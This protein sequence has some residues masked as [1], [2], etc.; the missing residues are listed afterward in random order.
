M[1][2]LSL[3]ALGLIFS[4]SV[5]SQVEQKEEKKSG[6]E[7]INTLFKKGTH[8]R[9]INIGYFVEVNAGYTQ[10][11]KKEVFLPGMTAGVILNHHWSFGFS[12]S[13]VGNSHNLYYPDFYYNSSQY[14]WKG[15]YLHGGFCG[16]SAEYT[17]LPRSIFHVSFPLFVGGGYL[18]YYDY[19]DLSWSN[20]QHWKTTVISSNSFFVVEP[21][22]KAEFN[23]IKH[24]RLGVGISYR[25]SPNL[26]LDQTASD[27]INQ[28][29]GK[30]SLR[31]G[32][33]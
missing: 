29:T 23:L 2:N 3:F 20:V 7:Q 24:L 31:F 33:F 28:F 26:K 25:Y 14:Q 30:L 9:K 1:K 17:L 11:G 13:F 22:I 16:F 27:Y 4:V 18:G 15:V 21:G 12:G 10:F 32:K 8:H 19:N 5:F 6:D